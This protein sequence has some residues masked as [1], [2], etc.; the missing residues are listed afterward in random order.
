MPTYTGSDGANLHY[1]DRPD[2]ILVLAGG[3]ARHPDYLGDLA[4]LGSRRR[5]VVPHLRGVG[6]SPLPDDVE[7]ASFWRQA[8]D[9]ERLR[10]HL[11]LD[12]VLLLGHSAGTRLAISYAAQFPAN[13]R[14]LVLVAPPTGYLV[15]GPPGT[16]AVIDARRGDPEFDAALAA[17][18]AGPS[19]YDDA[20][21]AAWQDVVA[22]LSYAVWG[23]RERAHSAVGSSSFAANRAFFSV[24]PP[25]DL[26][27]RLSPVTAPVLVVAGAQ[28][29]SVGV[30]GATALAKLFTAGE[31]AVIDGSG[32][33]PWVEQP[34]AF[35]AAVDAF[36]DRL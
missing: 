34:E 11:G 28:D 25:A 26:A 29:T 22:P 4:G 21:Y 33:L 31:I 18:E 9:I 14:G 23:P 17:W 20:G 24:D 8:E 32:H 19:T 30:A 27:A 1:D 5:L 2:P 13:V 3:A 10:V 36:L 16:D 35:R 15:D 7:L 12:R 6:R